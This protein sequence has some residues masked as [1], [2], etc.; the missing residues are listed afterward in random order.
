MALRSTS[1]PVTSDEL[2]DGSQR[3]ETGGDTVE[4]QPRSGQELS[5]DGPLAHRSVT[6][7]PWSQPGPPAHAGL[8]DAPRH[9]TLGWFTRRAVDSGPGSL[10]AAR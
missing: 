8:K 2:G 1:L 10:R 5:T 4:V 9:E 7:C 6:N 3:F